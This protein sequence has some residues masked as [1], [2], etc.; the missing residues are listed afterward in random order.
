MSRVRFPS[1]DSRMLSG[2]H[3]EG[4]EPPGRQRLEQKPEP[5]N[6]SEGFRADP[7]HG[8]ELQ[9]RK[10]VFWPR[11]LPPQNDDDDEPLEQLDVENQ[12]RKDLESRI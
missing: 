11:L 12:E 6:S 8:Q 4:D 7:D 3:R 9:K 5:E 2:T 1:R 10:Q